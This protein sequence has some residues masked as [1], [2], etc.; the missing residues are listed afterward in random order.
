MEL[1]IQDIKKRIFFI[2]GFRV[3]LDSDL[4]ELY[5]VETK[6][7]KRAVRRN[8][9]RFP[10]DFMF[11][12]TPSEYENL[13]C[14]IGTSSLSGKFNHGGIRY[15]PFVFTQE[16]VAML[17]GV[18][19]S[20]GAIGVNIASMRAFVKMRELLETNKDLAI[21]I[22]Q[23]ESKYDKQFKIVFDAIREIITPTLPTNRRRIGIQ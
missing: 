1:S 5:N 4:A 8:I 15:L 3:M 21:K 14:Q 9:N 19:H 18:L 13:R 10:E 7:L 6:T 11:Q 12:L 16:G 2:R 23:L 17:S 20:E 22:A